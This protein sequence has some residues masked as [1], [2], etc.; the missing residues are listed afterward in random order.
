ME[1]LEFNSES[2]IDLNETLNHP[3]SLQTQP[4]KGILKR[5]RHENDSNSK[6]HWDEE[7]ITFHDSQRG[8]T[9]KISEPKTPFIHYDQDNDVLL[10]HRGGDF[11]EIF[12][13]YILK[14][15]FGVDDIPP[16]EL[17]E[18]IR[19]ASD[20]KD[21]SDLSQEDN[22][23]SKIFNQGDVNGKNANNK[24]KNFDEW[25]DSES[26]TE[27]ED[28]QKKKEFDIHRRGHYENMKEAMLRGKHLVEDELESDIDDQDK[29][30]IS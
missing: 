5:G 23:S 8:K 14:N 4:K 24:K 28:I 13:C 3:P 16:M 19:L 15:Y 20:S 21:I 30:M 11:V 1:N 29:R 17:M 6:I 26:E 12:Y 25:N 10:G 22:C 7:L 18:A 2:E 27:F 9:M